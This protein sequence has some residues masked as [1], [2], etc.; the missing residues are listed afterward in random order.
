LREVLNEAVE[1]QIEAAEEMIRSEAFRRHAERWV[2]EALTMRS[3]N[4]KRQPKRSVDG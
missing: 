1:M 2:M 4:Y 3:R